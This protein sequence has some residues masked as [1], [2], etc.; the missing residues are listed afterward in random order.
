MVASIDLNQLNGA[1]GYRIDGVEAA[2]FSGF[3][4]SGAGDVNGDGIDD[5]IIGAPQDNGDPDAVGESYVVFG[6]S[7]GSSAS[8]DLS[9]LNGANGFRIEGVGPSDRSG[10]SVSGAGDINGDGFADVIVGAPRARVDGEFVGQGYVVFGSNVP[11]SPSISLSNLDG[12][13]GFQINGAVE[14]DRLGASVSGAGDVN[15]DGIDDIVLGAPLADPGES[16]AGETYVIF[17]SSSPFAA[18]ID[19]SALDGTDGF[20]VIGIARGD[21]SG[22]AVSA[23]GDINGDGIGDVLIGALFGGSPG[24]A[25]VV[26]GS[27]SPFAAT[28]DLAALDGADGFRINGIGV[29]GALGSSVSQA[30]DFNGDGVDDLILGAP[31]AS[32]NGRSSGESYIV[33]GSTTGF[34]PNFDLS[35][36]DGSNGFRI[37]GKDISDR[38]GG[39]VSSAGDINGDGLADVIVG[40]TFAAGADP[41]AGEA[42][43]IYGSS[44]AFGEV[45]ELSELD[46]V[47]G[48]LV[49]GVDEGDRVGV[50]VGGAGDVNGDGSD[51]LILGADFGDRGG[52]NSGES[53]VVFGASSGFGA[54]LD[55]SSLDGSNG[56]RVVGVSH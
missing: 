29:S 43:V 12:T 16:F 11:F 24:E 17:G 49:P 56:F 47:N 35:T 42:Y 55:L 25:Y 37:S 9:T 27:S 31:F 51:D 41:L 34:A 39:S 32:P 18:S 30:G 44:G 19:V 4:V 26:F 21:R 36:L 2:D 28:L 20:T 22:E 23:A 38:A 3:S 40:A 46:G 52:R 6:S 10:Y 48:F 15:G 8:L 45:L 7:S 53:Y 14:G 33:F 50:S 5:L 13:N 1:N 54:S